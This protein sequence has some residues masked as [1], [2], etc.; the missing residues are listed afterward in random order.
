M[1][2][3]TSA[4]PV[5]A[6]R[7]RRAPAF[8]HESNTIPGRANRWLSW[9]VD[10][11]FVGFPGA[12]VRLHTRRVKV[13]GT[14]VRP[15][16]APGEVAAKRQALGLDPD[17]PV[18]V[19]TGGSQG[20]RGLNDLVCETLPYL[21]KL[22]P[23]LQLLHLTGPNDVAKLEGVCAANH[24]R[25]VIRPFS[26]EMH[27]VLGAA[28]VVISRAGASSLAELAAMRVPA[29]LVPYPAALDNH[30]YFNA[31]ALEKTGAVRMLE[32]RNFPPRTLAAWVVE[33]VENASVREAMRTALARWHSPHAAE[34]IADTIVE[35]ISDRRRA[36]GASS[37][38]PRRGLE[39]H[40]SAV[41]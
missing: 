3:F 7:F 8:L 40:Q 5:L 21:A 35:A 36:A 31:V 16:F 29:I 34:Q 27:M 38:A 24:L 17:R 23:Q 22:A 15:E 10:Q 1:G 13:T 20:A 19:V 18:L 32:Q 26:A 12:G 39:H 28:S 11:A 37:I 4:P 41:P 2:G 25:A 14:P 6:G 33:L 9:T 30:Q